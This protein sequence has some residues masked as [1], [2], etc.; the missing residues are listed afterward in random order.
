MENKK[1]A[2]NSGFAI[3]QILW[4]YEIA[5]KNKLITKKLSE[6]CTIAKPQD[7]GGNGN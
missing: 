3:V 4:N 5:R 6:V 2:T 1:P 7:V